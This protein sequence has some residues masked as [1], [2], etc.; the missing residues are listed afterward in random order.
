M[1]KLTVNDLLTIQNSLGRLSQKDLPPLIAFSFSK[2][3]KRVDVLVTKFQEDR[4]ALV[5]SANKGQPVGPD[6]PTVPQEK[7]AELE[8][9]IKSF[10]AVEHEFGFE[11]VSIRAIGQATI[12]PVDLAILE[13]IIVE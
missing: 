5:Q 8:E 9:K 3:M 7:Q 11:P 2:F 1:L 10:L 6:E 4:A 13:G 12:K